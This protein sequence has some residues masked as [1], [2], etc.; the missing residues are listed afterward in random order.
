MKGVVRNSAFN[1]HARA[2]QNYNIVEDLAQTP[3]AMSDL[4]VLKSFPTK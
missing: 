4:E 3:S 1:P 2:A